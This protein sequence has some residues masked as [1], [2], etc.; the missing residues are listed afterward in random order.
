MSGRVTVAYN[1]EETGAPSSAGNTSWTVM[2]DLDASAGRTETIINVPYCSDS[3]F[4][5]VDKGLTPAHGSFIYNP[6]AYNG[7]LTMRVVSQLRSPNGLAD[8]EVYLAVRGGQDFEVAA[9]EEKAFQTRQITGVSGEV[10]SLG[11]DY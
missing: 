7:A 3:H 11:Y 5:A 1:P 6:G 2:I 9:P 10:T 4:L 8:A